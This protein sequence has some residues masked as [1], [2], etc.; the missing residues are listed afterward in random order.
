MTTASASKRDLVSEM[1]VHGD[2]SPAGWSA[3]AIEQENNKATLRGQ[4]RWVLEHKVL[5]DILETR[6]QKS[7]RRRKLN[8]M[9]IH[10][11]PVV[12]TFKEPAGGCI[13]CLSLLS[14]PRVLRGHRTTQMPMEQRI[15]L[16]KGQS[17]VA[18]QV[19]WCQDTGLWDPPAREEAQWLG[20]LF[21]R[22][23]QIKVN[24]EWNF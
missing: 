13:R 15:L 3:G 6:N 9:N 21:L 16:L 23:P 8:T 7:Q 17:T 20:C 22:N 24:G 10:Q 14:F 5:M 4:C 19:L 18:L 1:N 12:P 11:G 2:S